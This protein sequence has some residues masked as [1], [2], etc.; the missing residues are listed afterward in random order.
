MTSRQTE[1]S[2]QRKQHALTSAAA[3]DRRATSCFLQHEVSNRVREDSSDDG[4]GTTST[5]STSKECPNESFP[6]ST[7]AGCGQ[8]EGGHEPRSE[9]TECPPATLPVLDLPTDAVATPAL[10]VV[11]ASKVGETKLESVRRRRGG[12][13]PHREGGDNAEPRRD[14]RPPIIRLVE[15]RGLSSALPSAAVRWASMTSL[16][17]RMPPCERRGDTPL[18]TVRCAACGCTARAV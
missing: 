18:L 9:A 3:F 8:G 2:T 17:R 4:F 14:P 5:A 11:S 7:R 15:L 16:R 13:S 6:S 1:R 12:E 10:A